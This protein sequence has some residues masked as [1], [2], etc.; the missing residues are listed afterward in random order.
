MQR[1]L[2][3]EEV[4]AHLLNALAAARAAAA[5]FGDKSDRGYVAAATR[6]AVEPEI[7][8]N[9]R[10]AT[11]ELRNAVDRI[12]RPPAPKQ[13]HAFRKL[14]FLTGIVLAVFYNPV[15]GPETRKWVSE[16]VLGGG[17]DFTYQ[18]SEGNGSS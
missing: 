14:L 8:G 1:A 6:V 16:S 4:R 11:S 17:D 12:Q 13:G 9:L 3:D 10:Q 5:K 2:Q 18:A 15:T 7:L